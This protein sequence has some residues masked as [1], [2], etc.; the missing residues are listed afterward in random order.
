MGI[1][2]ITSKIISDAE[3]SANLILEEAEKSSESILDEARE[4]AESIVADAKARGEAD[5]E[6]SVKR[7]ASV[8]DIDGRKLLLQKKQDLIEDCFAKATD[9]IVNMEQKQYVDFLVKIIKSTG[10]KEGELV[11]SKRDFISVGQ[12]VV[13]RANLEIPNSNLKLSQETK[14]IKGG[15]L[16]KSGKIYI[17]GSIESLIDEVKDEIT[18]KVADVLFNE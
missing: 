2:K 3:N 5:K 12:L 6:V 18:V 1:E 7:R 13:D 11:F 9:S 8:A 4:K 14:D 10:C 15:L 16:V 17:S